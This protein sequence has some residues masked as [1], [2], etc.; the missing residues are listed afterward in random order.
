MACKMGWTLQKTSISTNIKERLDYS[1]AVFSA[2]GNL[3]ANA[4]HIP[5]HLG[6][7]STGIRYQAQKYG[8]D[9]LRPGDV[10]LSNHPCAGGTHLPDLT[11]I[12]PVFDDNENPTEI[13]FFV[14]NRG[15][16]ARSEPKRKQ[17]KGFHNG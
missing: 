16:L 17:W 15:A 8:K 14:A 13:M 10:V 5:G 7:M 11:V 12:T 9:G 2:Q 6:S 3:V 4:P 1:C